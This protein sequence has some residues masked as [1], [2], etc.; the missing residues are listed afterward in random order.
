MSAIRFY[1]SF[2]MLIADLW[3]MYVCIHLQM[4]NCLL[5]MTRF[6]GSFLIANISI[7]IQ[8]SNEINTPLMIVFGKMHSMKNPV[9]LMTFKRNQKRCHVY[10]LHNFSCIANAV[11]LKLLFHFILF[12][13]GFISL[14]FML[15]TKNITSNALSF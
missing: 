1:S 14:H 2:W 15:M 5:K 6:A 8:T 9:M 7:Q 12:Q 3:Y 10:S 4:L 13:I 11:I